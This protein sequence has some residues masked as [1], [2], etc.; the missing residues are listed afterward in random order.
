M[1][2]TAL[3]SPS[4]SCMITGR[5][6]H[7]NHMSCITE[8]ATGYPGADGYIP[9][10]NGFLSEILLQQGLQHLLRRQVAP[11]AR[12]GD[13]RRRPVRPLAARPRFRALLRL[14][15]RRHPSVLSGTGPRQLPDRAG[16]DPR[17]GLPPHR[18][19]GREGQGDDRRRQAGRAQQAVLPVLRH[20]CVPRP[21]PRPERVGGQVQ[22]QVR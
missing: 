11:H 4:R 16:E 10:E 3:C 1:H 9:F 2:T 5:N 12:R 15:G 18:R 21:A 14:P 22:G 6:H 8:G 19:P 17:R 13:L 7:S 20:R